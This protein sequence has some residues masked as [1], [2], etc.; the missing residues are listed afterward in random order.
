MQT[1]LVKK[2]FLFFP[3][4][5][6]VMN[7]TFINSLGIIN[8]ARETFLMNLKA[9]GVSFYRRLQEQIVHESKFIRSQAR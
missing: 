8:H 6:F 4:K 5:F 9:V 2:M 3:I 7:E 1:N